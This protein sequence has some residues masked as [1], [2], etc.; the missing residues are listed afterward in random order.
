M[1]LSYGAAHLLNNSTIINSISNIIINIISNN[2]NNNNI[3][4]SSSSNN[5]SISSS[6]NSISSISNNR[7][8]FHRTFKCRHT[9]LTRT[10]KKKWTQTTT[11]TRHQPYNRR[12]CSP[13]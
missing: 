1:K 3:Y 10:N 8:S 6:I 2:N 4:I 11:K 9:F 12:R 13:F 7:K 5:N